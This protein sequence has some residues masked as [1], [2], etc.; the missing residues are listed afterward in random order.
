M[1]NNNTDSLKQT[2]IWQYPLRESEKKGPLALYFPLI[3]TRQEIITKIKEKPE[4]NDIFQQWGQEAKEEF[5]DICSGVKGLKI[6]YDG[7]FKEIFNP[8][9]T[10]ERLE[11]LLTLLFEKEI[12]IEAVLPNDTVRLGAESSLLYTDILIQ[13]KD[14]SLCNVEIQKI[15]YAFPGQRSACYSADH[16]LRQYKKVRSE[17]GKHFNYKDIK[18]VYTIVFFEHSPS[19]FSKFPGHF[20]HKFRQKSDSGLE[21]ELLQEYFF[22]PLDIFRKSMENKSIETELEAWL[23]FLSFDE[24]EWII[25]LIT[26]Y[27]QFKAMYQQLY[28]MCLNMEKVMSVYSKELAE[29]DR[30][31]VLYM[32]DEMQAEID[33][34]SEELN[35][36]T[37]TLE[38]K[39][40]EL[41][42]KNSEIDQK[43]S[44]LDQKISELDQKISDLEE[45]DKKIKELEEQILLLQSKSTNT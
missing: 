29:L 30:N 1:T 26:E 42:Q 38:Q 33:R 41:D 10:P 16:L 24:P 11:Q 34:K 28:E 35:Q 14:G 43:N 4:L 8:E 3:H 36:L 13:Q 19:E 6:V 5:L 37:Y 2:D 32:I 18:Q 15:G 45:R 22:L 25:K 9:S 31:T 7:V 12:R 27:P 23:V 44:E 21:L 40:C 17:K 20:C 39:K